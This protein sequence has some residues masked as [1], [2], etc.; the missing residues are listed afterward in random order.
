MRPF[1]IHRTS[2]RAVLLADPPK[3]LEA[4]LARIVPETG[5][6]HRQVAEL[7]LPHGDVLWILLF[8]CSLPERSCLVFSRI[9]ALRCL[10]L[11]MTPYPE[12]LARW[13]R[14]GRRTLALEARGSVLG[15]VGAAERAAIWAATVP[16]TESERIDTRLRRW[17]GSTAQY[18]AYAAAADARKAGVP[19]T[20]QIG[21]LLTVLETH[22]TVLSL[23]LARGDFDT[24]TIGDEKQ[25]I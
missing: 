4:D 19:G 6:R 1:P 3:H 11:W 5:L 10:R 17:T 14:T 22:P 9:C 18:R 20:V 15:A 13:L 25:N 23:R 24:P 16:H 21:D 12:I 8:A 2:R 7:V